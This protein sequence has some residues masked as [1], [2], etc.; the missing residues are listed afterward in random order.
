MDATTAEGITTYISNNPG[1]GV[2]EIAKYLDVTT[3]TIHR[4]LKRLIQQWTLVKKGSAPHVAYYL[5]GDTRTQ[6]TLLDRQTV[7]LLEQERY[8]VSPIGEALMWVEGFTVWC[9]RRWVDLT[10]AAA[11][12]V[13]HIQYIDAIRHPRWIDA[14]SK[15]D[16]YPNRS[17][18]SLRYGNIY[19]L[20]EFWKT[21][22]WTFMEIA[23]TQPS[24]AIFDQLCT[25]FQRTLQQCIQHLQID[26]LCFAQPTAK[27]SMQLMDYA[28][29]VLI[30][31]LPRIGIKK[32]KG[33][34]PPQK[35]L[36]HRSDRIWNAQNSFELERWQIHTY[37]NVLIID[38][39]VWSGATLN[40]IWT[41]LLNAWVAK[42]VYWFSMIGTANGIFDAVKKFE[43]LSAV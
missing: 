29:D 5:W 20:P 40:E 13:W 25:T 8:Q 39:A 28:K 6:N 32:V 24:L 35:T 31:T 9:E 22:Y 11:R 43:V 4:Y 41:K 14:T 7:R 17:L 16:D 36:K 23:K 27:R 33:Y 26:A 21:K 34:F 10:D 19:A 37:K 30:P 1:S 12:R 18:K 3:V 15:L 42:H 2:S 38:D